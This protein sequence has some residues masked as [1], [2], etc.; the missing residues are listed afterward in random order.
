MFVLGLL[1]AGFQGRKEHGSYV[2]VRAVLP[3]CSLR[4][5][6]NLFLVYMYAGIVSQTRVS[7]VVRTIFWIFTRLGTTIIYVFF[8]IF[9]H[10]HSV[11]FC[12]SLWTGTA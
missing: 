1:G 8:D 2:A 7:C 10:L 11:Y 6:V 5:G 4:G 12:S 3:R 9:L